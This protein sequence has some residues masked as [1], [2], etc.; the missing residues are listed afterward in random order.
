MGMGRGTDQDEHTTLETE[1][2]SGAAHSAPVQC[3]HGL[4]I[5]R[6]IQ[7]SP[8][9]ALLSGGRPSGGVACVAS[10]CR[11]APRVAS[12]ARS[13]PTGSHG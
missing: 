13:G 8:L 3:L 12:L 11:T 9:L 6:T 4:G 1:H 2:A 7:Q 10:V 5:G